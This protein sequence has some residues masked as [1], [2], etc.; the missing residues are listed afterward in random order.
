MGISQQLFYATRYCIVF[1]LYHP[2]V[3]VT[4]VLH[5]FKTQ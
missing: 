4:E 5:G 1:E 2:T 3:S